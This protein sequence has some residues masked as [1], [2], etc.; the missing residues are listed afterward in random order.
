[1]LNILLGS[2]VEAFLGIAIIAASHPIASM[3]TVNDTH[4]GGA[5]LWISTEF[6]TLGAFVPIYFQWFRSDRR[7]G[8]RSDLALLR[9]HRANIQREQLSPSDSLIERS[10]TPWELEWIARTGRAPQE[11]RLNASH[12]DSQRPQT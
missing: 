1:M 10:L 4:S 11:L 6:V 12:L 3:Y 9:R 8:D 7:A 5:L 2:A